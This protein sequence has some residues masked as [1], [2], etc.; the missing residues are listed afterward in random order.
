MLTTD[1]SDKLRK[2]LSDLKT[3][4]DELRV[5]A[6]LGGLETRQLWESLEQR[7]EQ[8][9]Q[10]VAHA[11]SNAAEE[12]SNSLERLAASF[13]DFGRKLEELGTIKS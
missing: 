4:R 7:F 5:R 12:V 2:R 10:K 3:L 6:H 1:A 9:E 8:I 13:K 11:G